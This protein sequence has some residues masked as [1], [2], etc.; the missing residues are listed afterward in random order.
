M[1]RPG[2]VIV[3]VGAGH[4]G[5]ER[6]HHLSDTLLDGALADRRK[7]SSPRVRAMLHARAARAH[8]KAGEPLAAWRQIDAAFDAYAQADVPEADLAPM[9]WINHGELHQVAASSAVSLGEPMR[10]LE[11]FRATLAHEGPYDTDREARGLRVV[12]G[13]PG[14]VLA[15]KELLLS[16]RARIIPAGPC[17]RPSPPAPP[18]TTAQRSDA[19][20]A[21][22]CEPA[23][24]PPH[25]RGGRPRPTA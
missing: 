13:R 2:P 24:V 9:Y 18:P 1:L 4:E 14:H 25:R 15:V 10:A 5:G 23:P 20:S 11:N 19:P 17:A 21:A 8:S 7:I 22:R 16:D 12:G 6:F 3:A